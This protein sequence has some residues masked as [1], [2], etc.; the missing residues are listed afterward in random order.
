MH[1]VKQIGFENICVSNSRR[2]YE[3]PIMVLGLKI[4]IW[5]IAR[6]LNWSPP[7]AAYMRQWT[8]PEMGLSSD[9]RQAITWTNAHLLSI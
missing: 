2:L 5:T 6:L 1:W 8:D 3:Q 7:S 4:G 9:R